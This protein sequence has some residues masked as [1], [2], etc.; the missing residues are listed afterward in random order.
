MR[1]KNRLPVEARHRPTAH[2]SVCDEGVIKL[3]RGQLGISYI[4]SARVIQ[5][6]EVSTIKGAGTE[7]SPVRESIE[8]WSFGGALLAEKDTWKPEPKTEV[9]R[10]G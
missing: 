6:I 10:G 1:N 4:N 5:V 8:Y 2:T 7:E 9:S 3:N